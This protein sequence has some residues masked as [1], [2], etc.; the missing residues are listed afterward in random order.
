MVPRAMF[1]QTAKVGWPLAYIELQFRM[2]LLR[3][4]AALGPALLVAACSAASGTD[5]QSAADTTPGFNE[6]NLAAGSQV[7]Y[8]VQARTA[9]ACR[10]DLGSFAQRQ[11]CNAKISPPWNYRAEGETCNITGD[12]KKVKLGTLDDM[13]ENTSDYR[14]GITVRY[15]N[16][17]VG[18]TALWMMPLFPNNDQWSIPDACDNLGSPY[19]VRDYMHAAGTLSRACIQ[20]G[21]DEYSTTP[22]WANNELERVIAEA[23]GRGMKVMLDVAFNHFGHN[24]LMYDY[25]DFMSENDRLAARQ[26]LN[27][28]WN[29]D[30]T[31]EA[32]LLH[33][34]LLDTSGKLD[35]LAQRNQSAKQLLSQLKAKCPATVGDGLVRAFNSYRIALPAEREQFPCDK[36][37]ENQVP[38]FYLGSDHVSPSTHLGDNFTNDWRDVKFLFHHEENQA[39]TWEFV[40]DR[41]YLFRVLNYWVSRGV[42]GFRFDHTTDYNGGM[43]S[44]EWKYLVSKV[45]YY[46]AKRG[47][48][49]PIYLAEEFG[50]QMEMNKVMDIMT[51][52]YVGDMTARGGRTK[53]TSSVENVMNNM[54]RFNDHAF[55]MSALETHDEKRLLDDTGFN[56][57]TGAGFW[58]LGATTRSTPMMLVGQEFGEPY[59]LGFKRSDVLRSRFEGSDQYNVKGNDLIAFYKNMTTNRLAS[60][61]RALLSPKQRF[62]RTKDNNGIDQ[63]IY[64]AAKWSDDGNLMFVVHNLWEQ[65]VAQ[66]YYIP[67]EVAE[68]AGMRD[69]I[70]YK[71][72]DAISG[73]Q[74]G[75]PQYGRDLKWSF[76][77][78]LDASTRAQ[79]LRLER[80]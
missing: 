26:D 28:V 1:R 42:D 54:Y 79:W 70:R 69:D 8:E 11:A 25:A 56:I 15:V 75:A 20:Q 50:D 40:R 35:Q 12:L 53:N 30:Q 36:P 34:E 22:C 21:K 6:L 45:D 44:N 7:L 71:L 38:G 5:A 64:A 9:N 62:L 59:G 27:A 17:K 67:Q 60:Q 57:W 43:G 49:R 47:Q 13:V 23:H 58:G 33:P 16:E 39:H 2:T 66:T 48:S 63:R 31:Y 29:F 32:N 14:D 77:V 68:A 78:A 18:A 24:Y 19:A 73:Q 74:K 10:S 51:E 4:S 76:Y 55:V 37:L 52:G 61:N 65:D 80:E 41:E 72:V 3:L 46:A